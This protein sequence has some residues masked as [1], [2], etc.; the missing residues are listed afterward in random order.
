MKL[1]TLFPALLLGLAAAAPSYAQNDFPSK[2]I[3][4]V[5]PFPPDRPTD[6]MARAIAN[7][8][9]TTLGQPSIIENR[10]DRATAPLPIWPA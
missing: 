10:P 7:E 3:M 2:P 1:A 4:L 8:A 5:V 6:A 9:K